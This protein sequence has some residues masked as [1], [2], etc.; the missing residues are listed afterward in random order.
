MRLEYKG[1]VRKHLRER[2]SKEGIG[3]M[4]F[5]WRWRKEVSWKIVPGKNVVF[6]CTSS[7]EPVSGCFEET[8]ICFFFCIFS[9]DIPA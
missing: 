3:V 1:Q 2:G 5:G 6:F 7:S 8:K 9:F 4:S